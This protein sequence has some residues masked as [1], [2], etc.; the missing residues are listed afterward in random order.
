MRVARLLL[1]AVLRSSCWLVDRPRTAA[2][3]LQRAFA[4]DNTP[5]DPLLGG[6]IEQIRNR[7]FG[8]RT[9]NNLRSGAKVLRKKLV[10]EKVANYYL[11]PIEK[12]DPL[13]VDLR[14][15]R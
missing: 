14:A 10:G 5:G 13:H 6:T 1:P 11:K 3:S 15:E 8:N 7:I 9:G 12:E 2:F 4:T